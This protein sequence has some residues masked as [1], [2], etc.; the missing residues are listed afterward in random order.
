MI[1]VRMVV[2]TS[3][4]LACFG[5][6][7]S[8]DLVCSFDVRST[9]DGNQSLSDYGFRV[10]DIGD[11]LQLEQRYADGMWYGLRPV[12]RFDSPGCIVFLHLPTGGPYD[13]RS[14]MLTVHQSG[15]GSLAI[16]HGSAGGGSQ[17]RRAWLYQGT[18]SETP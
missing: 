2:L 4:L 14:R 18:C 12:Q 16:H 1:F 10:R 5:Q 13:G 9:I 3:T 15:N 7:A 6:G 17:I 11:V 8:A